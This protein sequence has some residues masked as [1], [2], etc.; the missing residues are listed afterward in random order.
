MMMRVSE[1]LRTL[2]ILVVV[3]A[4]VLGMAVGPQPA[5]AIDLGGAVEDLVKI[6]GIGW[7]VDRFAGD[8]NNTINDVLAQR[9]AEIAGATK[10]VPILR[11]GEGGGTAVG[12]AQVQ[13]PQARVRECEAVAELELEFGDLRGRALLPVSTK[14]NLTDSVRGISG[15]GVSANIRFPI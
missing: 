15:V 13:G 5:R 2:T 11:V 1:K 14:S 6:F 12:A 10:V 9:E 8:I 4:F 3:W 7:V